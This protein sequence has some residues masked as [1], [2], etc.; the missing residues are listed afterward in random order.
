YKEKVLSAARALLWQKVRPQDF[1]TW[2]SLEKR[3][4]KLEDKYLLKY[5]RKLMD[6]SVRF[7]DLYKIIRSIQPQQSA[8]YYLLDSWN[9]LTR[10]SKPE[11]SDW[12]KKGLGYVERE[13][14]FLSGMLE[15]YKN[16]AYEFD[17]LCHKWRKLKTQFESLS[18]QPWYHRLY[19]NR[20]HWLDDTFPKEFHASVEEYNLAKSSYEKA[21]KNIDDQTKAFAASEKKL[22]DMQMDVKSELKAKIRNRKKALLESL[23]GNYP[24]TQSRLENAQEFM[25]AVAEVDSK[26]QNL[27]GQKKVVMSSEKAVENDKLLDVLKSAWKV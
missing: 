7:A 26:W 24:T 25:K 20:D 21:Q 6:L 14:K 19:P 1:Q 2:P 16:D 9:A 12:V 17:E 22:S 23:C 10:G 4:A 13:L 3:V 5:S 27:H 18:R 15:S 11:P 8:Q